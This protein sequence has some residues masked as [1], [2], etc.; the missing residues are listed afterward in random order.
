MFLDFED[1]RPEA[2]R[3]PSAISRREGVLLSLL[4][5]ALLVIGWLVM[6]EIQAADPVAVVPQPQQESVR[7][8]HMMPRVE[9]P[10]P[11][12][13]QAEHSDLDRRAASPAAPVPENTRPFSRGNTPEKVVGA[14]EEKRAGPET[15]PP[16]PA[17][18]PT[19]PS[20]TT[21]PGFATKVT[22]E[23][24]VRPNGGS[25]GQ[26][27][28]NLQQFVQDQNFD[29]QRG[30]QA[31]PNA[32]IQF[33]SKG[34]EFGPWLRRFVAQVKRNWFVPQAAWTLRGRVV[35]TFYVLR[36]GTIADIR[37]VKPSPIESFN[38]AAFN[39]LKLSNPTLPLP[40]EYPDD[41]AFFTVTFHYNEGVD[42]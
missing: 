23:T 15:S 28:R 24:P 38:T 21:V 17:P 9:L 3:V 32:D 7:F 33:D 10:K 12:P 41:R 39:S 29:N 11:P 25:L 13:P 8:V 2:P 35:I 20:S 16:A 18:V 5:H 1:Y 37:V 40:A 14:P 30:G 31:D 26:S 36:N 42:R 6:P 34:V 22:P 27:L 19:P 4:F